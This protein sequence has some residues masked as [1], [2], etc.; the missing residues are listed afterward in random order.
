MFSKVDAKEME[1]RRMEK[2]AEA[3]EKRAEALEKRMDGITTAISLGT[4][5][6]SLRLS[7]L[8]SYIFPFKI[9][10]LNMNMHVDLFSL[11][12]NVSYYI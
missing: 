5:C 10:I 11:I 4:V 12:N 8:S 1:K 7:S 6:G 2:R 3:M 9:S